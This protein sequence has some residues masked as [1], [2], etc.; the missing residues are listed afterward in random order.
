MQNYGIFL[1]SKTCKVMKL[2]A[3]IMLVACL[4]VSARG[5]TQERVT[6][7]RKDAPL[8]SVLDEIE[9]QTGYHYFMN[10][11]W[12]ADAKKVSIK[13]AN[14]DLKTV[15]DIC[16]KDQPLTYEIIKNTIV[17]RKKEDNQIDNQ[18]LSPPP[19]ISQVTGTVVN[20]KGEPLVGAS[21]F[22]KNTSRGTLTDNKGVFEL[23]NVAKDAVLK[24]S[25][26]GYQSKEVGVNGENALNIVLF[27][28]NSSLDQVQV[29]AY[30]TTTRRLSVGNIT[31]VT[32]ETI[33]KQP[34]SNMLL[35]L[36]SQVP[37]LFITQANGIN[38]GGST[39]RIQGQNSIGNGNDPFYVI[40][41]VPYASSLLQT[42]FD[43]VLGGGG[44]F[45]AGPNSAYGSPLNY[46]NPS[47]VESV[48][49]LK[50]ADATAIY[51]S[52]AANGAILITTKKG[53]AGAARFNLNLQQGYSDVGHFV[54]MMNTRQYLDMRYQA[55][56]N[57]GINWTD[58]SVSANDLKV[59]DTTRY[60]NWQ[61]MLIG[62]TGQYTNITGS[63]SGGSAFVQYLVSGTYNRQTTVFPGSFADQ[64][65]SVH[66]SLTSA[67]ANQKF[68]LQF[69]G[70]YML[71]DN[72]LPGTDLTGQA[73]LLEPDAPALYSPDGSLNWE[74]DANG[75]ST[76]NN[77]LAV[78][79]LQTFERK[80]NNL[81]SNA[82][83][84]YTIIPG[85][86][87][88]TSF[89][90][91]DMKLSDYTP[92]PL[93]IYPPE[94]RAYN[95]LYSEFANSTANSWIIEPQITYRRNIS[96]G[97]L[98]LLF[99]GTRQQNQADET[100]LYGF[101]YS[102]AQLMQD[103][104]AATT[105]GP[106][107]SA[108]NQYKYAALYGRVNYIWE[109]KYIIDLTG[110]RDGSS[111]FGSAT[112]YHDFWSVAAGWIFS[113]EAPFK[114]SKVLSFGKLHGSYG[115][116]GNDQ[117]Q[118]YSFLSIYSPTYAQGLPYQNTSGLIP[119]GLS[120]P[121]LEWE[122]TRKL[123]GGIDLGFFN[124]R[125]LLNAVY[126]INR[127]SNQLLTTPL[128]TITGFVGIPANLPATIQNTDWEFT[129]N[130]VNIKTKYFTWTSRFNFTIPQNKLL[131][132]PGIA[133]SSASYSYVIGQPLNMVRVNHFIGIDPATGQYEFADKKGNPTTTPTYP[134]DYNDPED[135]NIILN[136]NPKFYGGF[137]NT[138]TYKGFL[139]DFT[140]SFV[141][142]LGSNY[143]FY[144]GSYYTPGSFGAG[145][146]NQPTTVL[147][148]WQ[149]PGDLTPIAAYSTLY[150]QGVGNLRGSDYAYTDASYIRLH[151][152]SLSWQ[153]PKKWIAA[154]HLQ[155]TRI[156]FQ[157]QN[158]LMFTRDKVVADPETG[159]G[160][161]PPLRILTVGLKTGL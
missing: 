136:L 64:K 118:N 78:Y 112:Q 147:N 93:S 47:D 124:N 79:T 16:F 55:F 153:F 157:G 39:V 105:I 155:D 148:S 60:T 128:P 144:Y 73:I 49:I 90:Y 149:K 23:K 84:S 1:T 36:Q 20:D 11:Q 115:T 8:S 56:R 12:E 67:S 75:V 130:T 70:N 131:A 154:S 34:V 24:I 87:I 32:A 125:I 38:G 119:V 26:A 96:K 133:T 126:S 50:D 37:G 102:S 63:L 103:I 106:V 21:V 160:A 25:Y 91:T 41:G 19:L 80:T 113:E 142:Q 74:P 14:A 72:K 68:H 152:L 161:L 120:N 54:D 139:F 82:V 104:Q 109:D 13:V 137:Q 138:F 98:N 29:I 57:D 27:I 61:K 15:L 89:G 62:G 9:R 35:A 100:S 111:R 45:G 85:L 107:A 158:L 59:W 129:L 66:F 114:K 122:E 83:L 53:K 108:Y 123:Q 141:K 117:I 46:I 132:Y 135:F 17:I 145:H 6:L 99:G 97:K 127:S 69:S 143:N 33:E 7:S 86:D 159:L 88:K 150:S 5:Y 43:G 94:Q 121:Y 134:V 42:G 10:A 18:I 76:W 116:T 110:R 140:L 95:S 31:T 48:E 44:A 52:R 51:G 30:G 81:V 101:G 156:Y 3:M 71:D 58:P 2:T 40:D 92:F 151:N 77:P 65:G 22:V 146:S 4:Q 28:S